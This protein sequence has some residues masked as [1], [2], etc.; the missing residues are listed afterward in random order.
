MHTIFWRA[1]AP[2]FTPSRPLLTR[3]PLYGGAM[4]PAA[5]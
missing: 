1:R 4:F 3:R 5:T 2:L